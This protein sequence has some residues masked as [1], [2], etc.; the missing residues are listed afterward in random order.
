MIG[1]GGPCSPFGPSSP[2]GPGSPLSPVLPRLAKSCQ[3][4]PGHS[5][6]SS[7]RANEAGAV[8]RDD[9]ELLVLLT[10]LVGAAHLRRDRIATGDRKAY[11]VRA[12]GHLRRVLE[13]LIERAVV[14]NDFGLVGDSC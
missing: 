11:P 8:E 13:R 10:I 12:A 1:P 7:W 9:V 5:P 6:G 4:G 3:P 14:A 2:R